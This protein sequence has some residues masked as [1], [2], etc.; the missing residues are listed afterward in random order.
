MS[1]V[2][3]KVIEEKATKG[4]ALTEEESIEVMST[5]SDPRTQVVEE[6]EE[7]APVIE[8]KKPEPVVEEKKEEQ[9]G[10]F[11]KVDNAKVFKALEG[12]KFVEQQLTREERGVANEI[13]IQRERAR[14]AEA[15]R[16]SAKFELIKHKAATE[17]KKDPEEVLTRKQVSEE[18]QAKLDEKALAIETANRNRIVK[19][20]EREARRDHKDY[21]Q[22]LSLADRVMPKNADYQLLLQKAYEDGDNVALTMYDIITSDPSFPTLAKEVGISLEEP[23]PPEEKKVSPAPQALEAAKK[24]AENAAK[25][26]TTGSSASGSGTTPNAEEITLDYVASLSDAEFAALPKAKRNAILAKYG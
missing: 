19:M 13:R 7:K 25:T 21:D 8:E 14:R 23:K 10:R 24:L 26:P 4:E 1:E 2:D 11:P 12:D 6:A 22:V 15:E 9:H 17:I 20:W 16:D 18:F 5:S 3:L